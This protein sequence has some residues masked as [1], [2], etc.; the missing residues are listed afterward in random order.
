MQVNSQVARVQSIDILRGIIILIMALDHVRDFVAITPFAPEDVTQTTPVWFFTRWITHFCA[1]TFVFLAGMSAFLYAQRVTKNQLR[2]FLVTRGLWL[3]FIELTVVTFGITFQLNSFILQV[4]W[5]IGLSMIILALL[6]YLPR[7]VM[8]IFTVVILIGHNLLDAVHID[9]AWWYLFHEQNWYVPVGPISLT[10]IYPLIPWPAVMT[11]GFLMGE[12]FLKEQ[13]KRDNKLILIGSLTIIGFVVLRFTNVYG[14]MHQWS[15]SD[16]GMLY[17]FLD[18][19][20]TSK[21]PPSLLYLAMTLGPSILLLSQ[22]EKW[23]G[24]IGDFFLTF[25]RVPFFFYIIHFYLIHAVGLLITGIRYGD[26]RSLAFFDPK[27]WP[28]EYSPSITLMFTVWIGVIAIMYFL[29][30][31]FVG[32]KKQ[33]SEWWL[34]YL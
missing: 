9:S 12:L 3:I 15:V 4:I 29:C 20:N 30:R 23:K 16:R 24:K 25:G 2:K 33:R 21:Y 19:L 14:D 22:L 34:K 18:F 10:P 27:T 6:T 1:P 17:T 5:V 11:L 26:W 28:P 7:A 32:V 31:W 8:I 13:T